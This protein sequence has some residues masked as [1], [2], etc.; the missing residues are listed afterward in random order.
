MLQLIIILRHN[1]TFGS[2]S[3]LKLDIENIR[4]HRPKNRDAYQIM[5]KPLYS[6]KLH[7]N[8]Q[9]RGVSMPLT[10]FCCMRS[11]HPDL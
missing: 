2:Y 5:G 8:A 9:T 7:Q 4:Y 10:T 6:E 3:T 1:I 11:T